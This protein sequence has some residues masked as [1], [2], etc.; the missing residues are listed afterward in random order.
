MNKLSVVL[1]LTLSL[2]GCDQY[3]LNQTSGGYSDLASAEKDSC[4]YNLDSTG[5]LISWAPERLVTFYFENDVPAEMKQA[6]QEV[7]SKWTTASGESLIQFSPTAVDSSGTRLDNKNI[8]YW[9][10][11]NNY[12]KTNEQGRTVTRWKRSK[13]TDS[14]ILI[15]AAAFQ[16]FLQAPAVGSKIHLGSLLIH[17][18]GHALGLRH[19]PFSQSLMFPSLN[20][21]QV[22]TTLSSIDTQTLRCEYP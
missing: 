2:S 3:Q 19:I 9:I 4:F 18:F 13:I 16:F 12:F 6:I 22:R 11:D 21:L 20:Y 7:A 14:D 1:V 17:E 15:N 8:I 10:R 5:E